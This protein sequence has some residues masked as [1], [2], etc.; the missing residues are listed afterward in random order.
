MFLLLGKKVIQANR[1]GDLLTN[2][3]QFINNFLEGLA[4][5]FE[6][7]NAEDYHGDLQESKEDIIESLIDIMNKDM[8]ELV[9]N[10]ELISPMLKHI[11]LTWWTHLSTIIVK[12]KP[13]GGLLGMCLEH[14]IL[15]ACEV[16]SKHHLHRMAIIDQERKV[17]CGIIT[18]DMI[19]NYIIGHLDG[20]KQLFDTSIKYFNI[21]SCNITFMKDTDTLL[22]V[23]MQMKDRHVSALP[24]VKGDTGETIGLFSLR[25]LII[26]IR[27]KDAHKVYIYIL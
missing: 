18:H 23:L 22:A 12:N 5:E 25:D 8:R 20:E 9:N 26:L 10:M 19:I 3:S 13:V 2:D 27:T 17:V 14:S 16:M 7:A 15:H 6:L 24:I 4:N 21:G 1:R 11:K